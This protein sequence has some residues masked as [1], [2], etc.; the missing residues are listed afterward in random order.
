MTISWKDSNGGA[1]S[2]DSIADFMPVW[3]GMLTNVW[4]GVCTYEITVTSGANSITVQ[5]VK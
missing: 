4:N 5:I 3:T 1:A 2:V